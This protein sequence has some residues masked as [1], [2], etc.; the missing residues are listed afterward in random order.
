MSA[1]AP[2]P[3][4]GIPY[5]NEYLRTYD[6]CTCVTLGLHKSS[7][8]E[9]YAVVPDIISIILNIFKKTYRIVYHFTC[10]EHEVPDTTGSNCKIV[11]SQ[12]GTCFMTLRGRL[13]FRGGS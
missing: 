12:Y 3:T 13:E 10:I 7:T 8:A 4:P 11:G 9:V 2:P 6:T 1:S 5:E